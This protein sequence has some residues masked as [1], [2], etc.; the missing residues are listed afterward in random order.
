M[1]DHTFFH[2]FLQFNYKMIIL[3]LL[4]KTLCLSHT[5]TVPKFGKLTGPTNISN[6]KL[7][8][9]LLELQIFKSILKPLG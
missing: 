3:L 5:Y 4:R 9:L 1:S 6:G 8:P 2:R 7:K